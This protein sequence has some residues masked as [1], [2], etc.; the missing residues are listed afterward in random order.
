[1]TTYDRGELIEG[2]IATLSDSLIEELTVVSLVIIVFLWHLTSAGI[3]IITITIAVILSFI[4]LLGMN[5]TANIMSLGGIAIAIG[6]MVDSSIVIV[7]QTHKAG[8]LAGARLAG[9]FQRRGHRRGQRGR[10]TE[11]LLAA[12]DRHRLHADIRAGGA[13]RS[14]LFKPLAFTKIAAI[15]I[16]AG[17]SVTLVPALVVLFIRPKKFDFRPRWLCRVANKLI[18]GKIYPEDNTR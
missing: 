2:A 7:E 5:V 10:P 3:P 6:S 8:R 13:G 4:P 11:L 9:R 1:M 16:A 18:V 15:A 17:L 14:R 12:R